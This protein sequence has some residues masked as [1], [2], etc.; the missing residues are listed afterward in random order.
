MTLHFIENINNSNARNDS[1]SLSVEARYRYN[2]I[3]TLVH[4]FG[5]RMWY[6]QLSSAQREAYDK[7]FYSGSTILSLEDREDMFQA[8]VKAEFRSIREA[9]RYLKNPKLKEIFAPYWKELRGNYF[10]LQSMA[11]SHARGEKFVYN[12]F[13]HPRSTR[14]ILD[15]DRKPLSVSDYGQTHVRED[16]A[17]TFAH[18]VLGLRIVHPQILERFNLAL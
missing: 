8:L 7:H 3:Y 17:E 14:W 12:N 15:I 18:Y 2:A 4:E 1:V 13:V 5:H 10:D 9:I 16:Y 11:K 6:K